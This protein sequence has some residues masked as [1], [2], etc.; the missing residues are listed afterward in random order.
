MDKQFIQ[1]QL[2]LF[3]K[4]NFEGVIENA[5]LNIKEKF[6]SNMGTQIL[7]IPPIAP[8]EIPRL[9]LTSSE[10]NINLAKN[11]IDFFAKSK[12]FASD[13]IEDIFYVITKLG[14]EINRVG[15]VL[16]FFKESDSVELK[17]LINASKIN[18]LGLK[19]ITIRLNEETVIQEIK[20]NNSQMYVSGSAKDTTGVAKNGIVITRDINSLLEDA[21]NNFTKETLDKFLKE[22]LILAEKSLI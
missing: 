13:K 14:V 4:N 22:V 16:T 5:S 21:G 18:T 1:L 2:A 8:P 7:N 12:S 3:F 9:I 11:R 10:V 15:F 17:S 19:D 6:G 20:C